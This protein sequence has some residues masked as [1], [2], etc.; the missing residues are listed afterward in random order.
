MN[1][2][3]GL[4]IGI[5]VIIG[6]I[7]ASGALFTV[8]QTQQAIVLQFGDPKRVITEPGLKI[9]L[10][11]IQ[12]VRFVERRVLNLDPPVERVLLA[13]QRPLLVDSFVR[14]RIVDPLRFIQAAISEDQV[15]GSLGSIVNNSVRATLGNVTLPSVLS[16]ERRGLMADIRDRVNEAGQ[17]FGIEIVDVRIGRADL[18]TEVSQSVYDRMRAE[19]Q[20]DAAEFRARGF[21]LSQRIKAAADREATVIR[22]EAEREAEIQRGIGE[23]E[24]TRILNDAFGQDPEFFDFYRSMQAYEGSLAGESSFLV[25]SPDSTFFRFFRDAELGTGGKSKE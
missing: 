1:R 20:R 25:L 17:T 24:R 21:E 11:F 13:D 2:R 22:A 15:Q 6:A 7:I 14:Y 5:V 19:R 23:G 4:L 3:I 10:P 18:A 8:H 16:D 9:K 12:E